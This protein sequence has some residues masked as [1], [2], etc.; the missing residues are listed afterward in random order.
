MNLK[1][2]RTWSLQR[3]AIAG[4]RAFRDTAF[5]CT[6]FHIDN[7]AAKSYFYRL[8][9]QPGIVPR[10]YE[11]FLDRRHE[12]RRL[13]PHHVVGNNENSEVSQFGR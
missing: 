6:P 5:Y 9:A 2:P 8:R 7:R 13:M 3:F 10:G 12:L 11:L 4:N 1:S